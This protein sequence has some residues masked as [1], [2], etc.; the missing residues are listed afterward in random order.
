MK[1]TDLFLPVKEWLEENGYEVY[2]E[3]ESR[4]A[5]GRA[6][7]V[8]VSGPAVSV[9]EMKKTLS[10]EL[11]EQ[12]LRWK[13]YANYIYIALP[14][15]KNRKV[16]GSKVLEFAGIGILQLKEYSG[17]FEDRPFF[18]VLPSLRAKFN[19]RIDDH[20]RQSLVPR[21]KELPGGHAGGGYVTS[22]SSMMERVRDYLESYTV[23]VTKGGWATIQEIIDN[24]DTYYAVPK[25]SLANALL[26]Y[27]MDWCEV[28]I[29]NRKRHFR[30]KE[31]RRSF[32][33]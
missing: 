18:D 19:R 15:S 26:H 21:H 23:Q 33:I 31:P 9:V 25:A 1:E 27:E 22:Y 24:V 7:I 6:D 20:I 32:N 8:G 30:S 29:E 14:Y 2:T 4:K 13:P 5:G 3:V 10:L 12:A 28:K 17:I 11:I 16:F